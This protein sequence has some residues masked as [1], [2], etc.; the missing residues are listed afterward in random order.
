MNTEQDIYVCLKLTWT[1]LNWEQLI[2]TTPFT[3]RLLTNGITWPVSTGSSPSTGG[4]KLNMDLAG[5][6]TKLLPVSVIAGKP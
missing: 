1:F 5:L 6:V 3:N 4:Y 2:S